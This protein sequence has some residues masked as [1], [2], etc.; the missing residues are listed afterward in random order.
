MCVDVYPGQDMKVNKIIH[1]CTRKVTE[2]SVGGRSGNSEG[3]HS[4]K[5]VLATAHKSR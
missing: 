2:S 5:V 1:T 3:S 4:T